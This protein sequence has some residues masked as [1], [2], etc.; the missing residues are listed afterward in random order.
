MKQLEKVSICSKLI[1]D[2]IPRE[3][4]ALKLSNVN[5]SPAAL[6]DAVSAV[7]CMRC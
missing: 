3:L 4:L 6:H 7:G 2:D 1:Q 5:A